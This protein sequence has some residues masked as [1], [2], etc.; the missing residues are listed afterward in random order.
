MGRVGRGTS[1]SGAVSET[2]I[3]RQGSRIDIGEPNGTDAVVDTI[4]GLEATAGLFH[5]Y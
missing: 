5:T 4:P 3:T 1:D 2:D